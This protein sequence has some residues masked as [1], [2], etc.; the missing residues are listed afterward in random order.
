M[1][2]T[3][4]ERLGITP[5]MI[6]AFGP[7]IFDLSLN[8]QDRRGDPVR[9]SDFVEI[10]R[11]RAAA[12]LAD[13]EIAA[14]LGL[15]AD[16]VTFIRVLLEQRRF[17]PERYYRLFQ[18]GGGRRF[19]TERDMER[20]RYNEPQFGSEALAIRNALRFSPEHVRRH[21][22]RGHW[23]GDT[24]IT[25][26]Q[27]WALQTTDAIAIAATDRAPV[28]FGT[29]LD[30]A[31]R[32]AAALAALGIRR[33]DVIA[34]QLPST[35]EFIIIYY[36][37]A[38]LGAVLTTLH[39][40]YG[41]AEAEPILRHARA[42]AVFC[43]AA[44]DKSDPPGV[45]TGLGQH[46]PDLRHVIV[47]GSARAGVL[48]FD[49]LISSA[50]RAAL[51]SPP[52]ATDVAVMC[53]TS[54]TSSAPKAVPHSFQSLLANARQCLPILGIKPG[55]R[56]LSAAPLSHAFGL[57]VANAALMSGA[58]F[59]PLPM[60][61]P[62]ALARALHYHQP[63]H[64]FVAPAHIAALLNTEVLEGRQL[65]YPRQVV[66]SGS[67]CPPALKRAFEEKLANGCAFELWGMTET[68]AVLLGDP[69]EPPS[70]RHDWVGRPTPGSEA[71]IADPEGKIM[72]PN[73]E[74][75]LQVRGCSVF[76]GYFDN[77]AANS[78]LF[79]ED[80]WL[81]TGDLAVMNETGHVRITGRI[82][83]IINRGGVKLNPSDVEALI[84][85]HEAVLQSAIIPVPDP[86]LGER[87]CCCVVLKPRG[88]LSLDALC[89]WLQSKGVAKAKWPE[90][91][92]SIAEMPMTPTRKIIKGALV[93]LIKDQ[94]VGNSLG[95][96]N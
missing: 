77:A 9:L 81:R 96:K 30:Q 19:R 64:L 21:L 62:S 49:T 42:R 35:A 46:L 45:F 12:G 8:V 55:D 60:F 38:R 3:R 4:R 73:T 26:L 59:V 58:T 31:E 66:F 28:S 25:W 90:H 34:V 11:Q 16:Q 22:E 76:A 83:D 32:L 80:G 48:A 87:A 2:A 51:P 52:V 65:E 61:S 94:Q 88:T 78:G 5:E 10:D 70:A 24:L 86:I 92:V 6:E 72:P 68:F 89:A 57:Y 47:V 69:S 44:S 29:A 37:I 74:G 53:Y 93:K 1:A 84:D 82:K 18:L 56:V 43:G 71:R 39:M 20:D 67:Y 41:A 91:L 33:G 85:Q 54:G 75:E 7:I 40:A 79:C 50:D 36:A 95:S 13:H 17:K 63:T 23:T 15:A 27:R 14:R